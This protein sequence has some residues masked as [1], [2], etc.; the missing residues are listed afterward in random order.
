MQGTT[1]PPRPDEP[2][3]PGQR[4]DQQPIQPPPIPADQPT[5]QTI[6]A[7][8]G[9]PYS[10]YPG[11]YPPYTGYTGQDGYH[12]MPPLPPVAVVDSTPPR[13]RRRSLAIIGAVIALL[14]TLAIGVGAGTAIGRA[15]VSPTTTNG[16]TVVLGSSSAPN[17]TVSS[18]TTSLQQ[19]VENISKAVA[20]S[21]VKITSTSANGSQAVGSGNILTADGYIVTN[22]H[23]VQGFNNYTVQ[24]SN[25]KTYTATLIG[26]APNDD[27]AVIKIDATGLKPI[28]FGDSSKAQVGQFVIA[29]GNPLDLG[30][31]VTF[32][33]V[34]RLNQV[35]SEQPSGPAGTLTGLIQTSAPINPG[36]S[37]GA[38]VNLQGQLIGI[39]TL[40]AINPESRGTSTS[41]GYAIASNRVQFVAQQLIANGK[42]T[43]TGQ[44]FI[45]IQA[46]DV[47]PQIAI[48]NGLS[49]QS[50][51]LVQGFAND[52]EGVSPGQQA[53][54]QKGDVITA[55]NGTA[56]SN[57]N[58]LASVLQNQGPGKQVKLTVV[59]G[60]S[61]LTVTVTLGERPAS[62]QG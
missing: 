1:I 12:G 10:G 41:I 53:G 27:L 31:S 61:T 37:G 59:R 32:G 60:T 40:A 58:D 28:A 2:S 39:P 52:A 54:L 42:V 6:P 7:P 29:I 43:S 15:T 49:V 4:P 8:P 55:V 23:V 5:G 38:L 25:G 21:V 24:L 44:G 20:P 36:N 18:S 57:N 14:L 62:P 3:Q 22:D 50:G 9:Y 45:G 16:N 26:E 33:V 34:S 19:D 13:P 47:T 46:Q 30:E 56:V 11:G 51:V 17:V 35:A 48:A